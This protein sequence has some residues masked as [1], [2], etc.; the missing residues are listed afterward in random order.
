[1]KATGLKIE[2][3]TGY[4]RKIHTRMQ[5]RSIE[6]TPSPHCIKLNLNKVISAKALTL[7]QA[8][9]QSDTPAFG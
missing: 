9:T 1:M 5:L 8:A 6:T 7:T 4:L 3:T 2:F